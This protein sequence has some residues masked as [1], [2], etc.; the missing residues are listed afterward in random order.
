MEEDIVLC[1]QLHFWLPTTDIQH[2]FHSNH[3]IHYV[4][5]TVPHK[6]D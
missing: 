6:V 1:F 5:I 2:F 3:M 4:D